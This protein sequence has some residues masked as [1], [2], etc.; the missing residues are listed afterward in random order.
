LKS[1]P[2]RLFWKIYAGCALLLVFAGAVTGFAVRDQAERRMVEQLER[3][4]RGDL[5]V[6][7]PWASEVLRAPDG[8]VEAAPARLPAPQADLGVTVLRSDGVVL[9]ENAGDA[10]GS[11]DPSGQ[12]EI[13]QARRDGFGF[14]R[15][16]GETL[17]TELC[18]AASRIRDGGADLGF[19]RLAGSLAPIQ[20]ARDELLLAVVFATLLSLL[21]VAP[22]ALLVDHGVRSTVREMSEVVRALRE[23]RFEK[24]ARALPTDEFGALGL[25]INRLGEE[26]EARI[27]AI[28]VEDARLRAMLAGMV[29]GVVALDE[30][31]RVTFAN[32][33]ARRLLSPDGSSLEARRLWEVARV[34]EMARLLEEARATPSTRGRELSLPQA[35]GE[36]ILQVH[37][38]RFATEGASTGIV[39][40]FHDIT[41]LRKLERVRR[42]FVANVSHE[43]KTPLTAIR[44]YVETLLSGAMDDREDLER[45][46]NK[47]AANSQ[48][49]SHLVSDLLSLARIES[50][51]SFGALEAMDVLAALDE[52]VRRHEPAARAKGLR[53]ERVES[54]ERLSVLADAEAL[55]QI[56]DN[57]IDNAIKYTP[58][59]S[60]RAR[61]TQRGSFGC[62]EIADTGLGIPEQ[63]RERVFER[64]FRV[65]RARSREVGGTGLGLS[66]VKH[67]A[68]GMKGGVELESELGRGSS[69]RVLLALAS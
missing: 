14:A 12:P 31:D 4:L 35:R 54:S 55:R 46:L 59:G 8:R 1:L 5:A 25:S 52:A 23:G 67:L 22:L 15:R 41:E 39:V 40:V 30:S 69:F 21:L 3:S 65:D 2:S 61:I 57:L 16:S 28:T 17:G 44:G 53:L 34:P 64:F 32:D 56:L 66:I 18:Y 9:Y 50:G 36:L 51:E 20:A 49:L 63:D 13:V 6:L 10:A 29:E 48:R 38:S 47:V 24:R 33:A 11:A 37:A 62:I 43:L 60:I 19:L 42:D 7:T 58:T 26:F 27:G 68:Q 45:F